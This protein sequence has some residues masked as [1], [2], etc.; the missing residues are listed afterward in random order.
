MK[1]QNIA[2]TTKWE[3]GK[4]W[5]LGAGSTLTLSALLAGC[6]A[7]GTQTAEN[8]APNNNANTAVAADKLTGAGS[9]FVYP[10]MAKWA[11]TY[12]KNK[13]VQINYQSVGS[14]AG[15]KQLTEQT[16]DFGASDAPLKDD[17]LKKMPSETLHVPIIAGGVVMAYNL[18]G[19]KAKLKMSGPVIADIYLG[20]IKKWNDPAIASLNAD[21]KLPATAITV[22]HRSDGSGTTY[23]FTNY[24]KAASSEWDK[25][26]GAGKSV[27][28]PVGL[29][30]KGNEGVSGIV[31]Q[32]PGGIGYVELAYAKQ[33]KIAYATMK[34]AAGQFVD[35]TG[36]SISAA[37]K[38]AVEDLQK[39]I[40]SP[41]AN[42]KDPK[43]YP[44]S[45]FTYILVYAKQKD[46][47]KGAALKQFLTWAVEDGQTM[48]ADL[49]YAPLPAE[50]VTMNEKTIE[51]VQ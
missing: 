38:G 50:V 30:G 10:I 45:G 18:P 21:L 17:D 25:K 43:A 23:I 15:I 27:D 4:R 22:A 31:K 9:T 24:L 32:S 34:N 33:N 3:I 2:A 42:S 11:D 19:V 14:G 1:L 47:A 36:D 35:A 46:A 7:S 28:W 26:V 49:D 51:S 6:G 37:A 5:A 39:D 20:K 48:A 16:V 29:G 12:N 8:P 41:I 44:I 40:R 13:G